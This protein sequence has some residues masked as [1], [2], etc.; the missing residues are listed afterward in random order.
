[1]ESTDHEAMT[2]RQGVRRKR[3][4]RPGPT[5]RVQGRAGEGLGRDGAGQREG[6]SVGLALCTYLLLFSSRI[7]SFLGSLCMWLGF[8][9]LEIKQVLVKWLTFACLSGCGSLMRAG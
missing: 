4:L 6:E 1:M 7:L 5:P 8:L 2:S 9:Q 3:G